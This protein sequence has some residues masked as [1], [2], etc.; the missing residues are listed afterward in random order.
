MK[1]DIYK[2]VL[3]AV[4]KTRDYRGFSTNYG[5]VKKEA[6]VYK[7]I[8]AGSIFIPEKD[9]DVM[10]FFD[11]PDARKAGYNTVVFKTEDE[12]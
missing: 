1:N 7:T 8:C 10:R 6:V 5:K 4:T 11:N 9:K 12:I 2:E 3:F